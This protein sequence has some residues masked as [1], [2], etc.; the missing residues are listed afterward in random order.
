M[1]AKTSQIF[2]L[3][4]FLG[5]VTSPLRSSLLVRRVVLNN[6]NTEPGAILISDKEVASVQYQQQVKQIFCC[7]GI[8]GEHY[9]MTQDAGYS[10]TTQ[11]ITTAGTLL[12]NNF[13]SSKRSKQEEKPLTID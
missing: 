7:K 8:V 5:Q 4:Y 13:K 9:D 3:M 1:L 12:G 11:L 10:H 6:Y 2:E